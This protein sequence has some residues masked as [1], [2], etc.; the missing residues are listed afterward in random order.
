MVYALG[1]ISPLVIGL[2]LLTQ[3]IVAAF[4]GWLMFDET[5]GALDLFGA[6]LVGLALVLVRQPLRQAQ[7]SRI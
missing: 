2:T 1:R 6:V 7:G 5:L 3:P 4:V